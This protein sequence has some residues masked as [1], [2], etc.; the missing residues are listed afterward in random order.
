MEGDIAFVEESLMEAG[1]YLARCENATECE[2]AVFL[3]EGL[4]EQGVLH[5]LIKNAFN[6][7]QEFSRRLEC[8]MFR[9]SDPGTRTLFLVLNTIQ[10]AVVVYN[11]IL[12]IL[13]N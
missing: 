4:K 7:P 8:A 2:N 11:E 12:N 13:S 3:A 5:S 10:D 9:T 6:D 1:C